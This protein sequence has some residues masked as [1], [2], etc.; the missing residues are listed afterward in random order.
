MMGFFFLTVSCGLVSGGESGNGEVSSLAPDT[1]ISAAPNTVAF[2]VTASEA[3]YKRIPLANNLKKP[4]TVTSILLADNL[5]ADFT[6]YDITDSAGNSVGAYGYENLIVPAGGSVKITVKYQISSCA[7]K[8]YQ[9]TLWIYYS[10]GTKTRRSSIILSPVGGTPPTSGGGTE[11]CDEDEIDETLFPPI[12]VAGIPEAGDY[13]IRVDRMASYIFPRGSND[14]LLAGQHPLLVGTDIGVGTDAYTRAYLQSSILPAADQNFSFNQITSCNRF[15][16]PSPP[17]D[18]AFG[19]AKTEL[20][21]TQ[22]VIGKLDVAGN[23]TIEGL[24]VIL[25]TQHIP[26]TAPLVA[27]ATG[28]FRIGVSIQKLTTEQTVPDAFLNGIHEKRV[29]NTA[30]EEVLGD[31]M[32]NVFT[33]ASGN[34]GQAGSP[35]NAEGKITLV[36]RGT[37]IAPPTGDFLGA[38]TKNLL[39]DIDHNGA[40]ASLI[41]IQIEA[42][43]TKKEEPQ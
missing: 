9:T 40:H 6:I 42:T 11:S 16:L 22:T 4:I 23:L 5:C 33:D 19:G 43:L 8:T 15:I 17:E 39:I 28:Q 30:G 1:E 36:G 20:T 18:D 10:D 31:T 32:M 27:D 34:T 35:L 29:N 26:T 25:H 2:N 37:F 41:Y 3:V 12:T 38:S 13:F 24:T 7:Y 14:E 21:S